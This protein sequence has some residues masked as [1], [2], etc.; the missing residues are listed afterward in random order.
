[1]SKNIKQLKPSANSRYKQGYI[2]QKSCR[3][4]FPSI[5]NE[6]IIYRSSYERRFIYWCE[7]NA[8]VKH[9]GSEC[10]TIPYVLLTD[11]TNHTYNPDFVV[12]MQDG[13]I[14]VIEI[15]PKNQCIK[16]TGDSAYA[17]N[18]YTK[19]ISKWTAAKRFCESRG[20]QFKVLTEDTISRLV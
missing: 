19:N 16:P 3:K 4:L 9:W 2:D 15:K 13:S 18:E 17:L 12:E 5:K 14:Y 11:H 6:N 1:M 8:N 20:V 7:S 10:I